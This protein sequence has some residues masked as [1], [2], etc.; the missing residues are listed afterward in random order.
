MPSALP[1]SSHLI[2]TK[3]SMK[4]I[5]TFFRQLQLRE[6][7]C[8]FTQQ[9]ILTFHRYYPSNWDY[10][11]SL[12]QKDIYFYP[13]G[14]EQKK[15]P[16]FGWHPCRGIWIRFFLIDCLSVTS[17]HSC[18]W[19]WE[20]YSDSK[21]LPPLSMEPHLWITHFIYILPEIHVT[22]MFCSWSNRS[23]LL[24]SRFLSPNVVSNTFMSVHVQLMIDLFLCKSYLLPNYFHIL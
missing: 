14:R 18:L 22:K 23:E 5:S 24:A 11:E 2:C 19:V 9:L 16:N 1:K 7:V 8:L 20:M 6:V 12:N 17:K 4:S 13:V 10:Y 15:C 21:N 3:S